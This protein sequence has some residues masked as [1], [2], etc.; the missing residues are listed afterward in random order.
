MKNVVFLQENSYF[1][2]INVFQRMQKEYEKIF[3]KTCQNASKNRYKFIQKSPSEKERQN[4]AKMFKN[5]CPKWSPNRQN[6]IKIEVQR[7]IEK[8][9]KK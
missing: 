2:E 3:K 7:T 6:A 8:T 1:N 5:E 9:F 4:D